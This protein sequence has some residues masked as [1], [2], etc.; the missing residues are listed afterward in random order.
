MT[1][2]FSRLLALSGALALLSGCQLFS[3]HSFSDV[4]HRSTRQQEMLARMFTDQGRE[5]LRN[6]NN[7]RAIEAFNLALATGE[8]PA[9]AYNGLGVAYARIGRP[10]LAYRFFSKA[11]MSDPANPMFAQNLARLVESPQFAAQLARLRNP[12]P[13][14][15]EPT[16][17]MAATAPAAPLPGKLFRDGNRQFSLVTTPS[18]PDATPA[19]R[20]LAIRECRAPHPRY[21]RPACTIARLP[22]TASRSTAEPDRAKLGG[23]EPIAQDQTG[24]SAHK[25]F[26]VPAPIF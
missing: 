12:G 26:L 7:G 5:L 18:Q 14:D 9:L 25:V 11:K 17:T 15:S 23:G 22:F 19:S 20:G 13:T 2:S 10:D 16:E 1:K 3:S 24:E 6:G 8:S 4:G 21:G